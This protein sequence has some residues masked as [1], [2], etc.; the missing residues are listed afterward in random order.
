MINNFIKISNLLSN[1]GLLENG[2]SLWYLPEFDPW[3]F[4]AD[5]ITIL[6]KSPA[7]NLL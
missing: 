6:H 1:H 3:V 4:L 7:M 2:F 5:G